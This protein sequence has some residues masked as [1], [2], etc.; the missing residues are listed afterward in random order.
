MGENGNEEMDYNVEVALKIAFKNRE[1]NC[2]L[3]PE[4]EKDIIGFLNEIN[5][6]YIVDGSEEIQFLGDEEVI[7]KYDFCCNDV[8]PEEAESFAR[9]KI[10]QEEDRFEE[11]GFTLQSENYHAEEADMSW[12]DEMERQIFG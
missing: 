3:R 1:F 6:G 8:S 12:L 9:Y 5:E 2:L 4:L 7:A 11:R 10:H